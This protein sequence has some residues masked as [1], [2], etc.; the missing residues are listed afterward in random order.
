MK[1]EPDG[2]PSEIALA[3]FNAIREIDQDDDRYAEALAEAFLCAAWPSL[4]AQ[5]Q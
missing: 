1:R 2:E 4:R 3:G 5:N